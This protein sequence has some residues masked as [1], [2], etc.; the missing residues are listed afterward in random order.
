[1]RSMTDVKAAITTAATYVP[2]FK[3]TSSIMETRMDTN[4]NWIT[5]STGIQKRRVSTQSPRYS[6]FSAFQESKDL[7]TLSTP[8]LDVT[9]SCKA[10]YIAKHTEAAYIFSNNFISSFF[11]FING[12]SKTVTYTPSGQSKK[13]SLIVTDG[14]SYIMHFKDRSTY[15]AVFLEPHKVDFS[16]QE[17]VLN[18]EGI[19]RPF[20]RIQNDVSMAPAFHGALDT[21]KQEVH[22]NKKKVFKYVMFN[23][24]NTIN[25]VIKYNPPSNDNNNRLVSYQT[26]KKVIKTFSKR[27]ELLEKRGKANIHKYGK[28]TS[29]ALPLYHYEYKSQLETRDYIDLSPLVE[30]LHVDHSFLKRAINS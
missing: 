18:T 30:Y 25:Q 2:D 10:S 15:S 11:S 21:E 8:V 6:L 17:L 26:N 3:F 27:E 28:T 7:L 20:L 23:L 24:G 16:N 19:G 5:S 13:T 4:D 1:M 14:M 9:I 12:N 29:A 22:Q